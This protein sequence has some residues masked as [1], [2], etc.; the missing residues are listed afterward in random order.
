[1]PL[2]ERFL[3]TDNEQD[4]LDLL[5]PIFGVDEE[6]SLITSSRKLGD[7]VLLGE[8][9]KPTGAML[10]ED[11]PEYIKLDG[12]HANVNMRVLVP[13]IENVAIAVD[14]PMVTFAK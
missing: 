1:M 7:V 11:T 13:E 12:Y 5:I 6:G 4:M 9:S 14:S 8:L 3:K 10:D 2:Y